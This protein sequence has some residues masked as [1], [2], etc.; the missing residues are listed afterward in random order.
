MADQRKTGTIARIL[1]D[2][3]YGFIYCEADE[4]DYFFH[5]T[6][7]EGCTLHQ[8]QAGDIVTFTVVK[9]PKGPEAEEVRLAGIDAHA[10][11]SPES[12]RRKA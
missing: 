3:A 9:G 7:L 1:L 5:Q 4:R 2:R 6:H 8:L 12:L 11:P 10:H